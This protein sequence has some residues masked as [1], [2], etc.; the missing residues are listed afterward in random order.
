M[1][2]YTNYEDYLLAIWKCN[3]G[4]N[5][6]KY[7]K[8]NIG[9]EQNLQNISLPI[10]IHKLITL[11]PIKSRQIMILMQDIQLTINHINPFYRNCKQILGY[12]KQTLCII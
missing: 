9:C 10:Y 4:H 1:K 11:T 5:I 2:S 12:I 7:T 6:N 8:S 3:D